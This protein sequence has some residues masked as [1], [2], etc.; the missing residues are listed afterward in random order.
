[1]S[2]ER[3][4]VVACGVHS[5]MCIA[6]GTFSILNTNKLYAIIDTNQNFENNNINTIN[7]QD[8]HFNANRKP[9]RGT[10]YGGSNRKNAS[11]IL[12]DLI[13]ANA[14][15][16]LWTLALFELWFELIFIGIF[17]FFFFAASLSV[18]SMYRYH[19]RKLS[20]NGIISY[21]NTRWVFSICIERC[22]LTFT[23]ASFFLSGS[24]LK[25][26]G[27]EG[28]EWKWVKLLF[29]CSFLPS[30]WKVVVWTRRRTISLPLITCFTFHLQLGWNLEFA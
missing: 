22:T 14:F 3:M 18:S 23:A 29:F 28:N 27:N 16:F 7:I 26:G 25:M 11:P 19:C 10:D 17:F 1:M 13:Y 2:I 5:F 30:R 21:K 9:N 4:V 12:L 8:S 6:C 20:K 15:L 24:Q